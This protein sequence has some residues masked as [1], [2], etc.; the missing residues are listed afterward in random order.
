MYVSF[1]FSNERWT[2]KGAKRNQKKKRDEIRNKKNNL[3]KV[4]LVYYSRR[5]LKFCFKLLGLWQRSSDKLMHVYLHQN[6]KHMDGYLEDKCI[7]TDI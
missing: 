5:S 4:F 7:L 3:P 1:L 2:L 6:I